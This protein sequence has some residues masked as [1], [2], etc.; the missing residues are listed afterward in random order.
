VRANETSEDDPH[1][2]A[3]IFSLFAFARGIGNI[4]SGPISTA[5]LAQ[6]RLG[7]AKL[8][9]GVEN[10]V[11]VLLLCLAMLRAAS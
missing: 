2:P 5:L 1:L 7:G 10:Y 6:N 4:V 9:Y 11:S 8:G 3:T